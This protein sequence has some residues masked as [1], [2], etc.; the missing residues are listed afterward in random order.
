MRANELPLLAGDSGAQVQLSSVYTAL[1]TK[2]RDI[3]ERQ[4]HA[5][6]HRGLEM[7]VPA[8]L[9]NRRWR[10]WTKSNFLC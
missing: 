3:S 2:S 8:L 1:L 9:A 10:R 6:R 7:D 4:L 5:S